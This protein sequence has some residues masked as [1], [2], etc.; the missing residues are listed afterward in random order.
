MLEGIFVWSVMK[1]QKVKES[2][3]AE[4][5]L[6]SSTGDADM[7]GAPKH[8]KCDTC[9]LTEGKNCAGTIRHWNEFFMPGFQ[10]YVPVVF[11]I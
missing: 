4:S 5:P 9:R 11:S 1:L 10:K 2:A 3:D 8:I 7:C 6:M